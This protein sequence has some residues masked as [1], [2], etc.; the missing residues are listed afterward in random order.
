MAKLLFHC[1][2]LT[3]GVGLVMCDSVDTYNEE[4]D[5]SSNPFKQAMALIDMVAKFNDYKSRT[6]KSFPDPVKALAELT[7]FGAVKIG[8]VFISGLIILSGFFPSLLAAFGIT[9]PFL[10]RSVSENIHELKNLNY[11]MVTRSIRTL[12]DKSFEALDVKG[13]DCKAR[14]VCEIGEYSVKFFPTGAQYVRAFGN[15]LP[16]FGDKYLAAMIKGLSKID[17]AKAYHSCSQSPFKKLSNLST[18]NIF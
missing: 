11:E 1:L 17:C 13:E 15:K 8:F 16:N 9:G 18:Y 12:P 5:Q 3:I 6:I 7:L 4:D 2:L 10:I 14:A